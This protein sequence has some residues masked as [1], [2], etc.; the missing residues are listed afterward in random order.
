MKFTAIFKNSNGSPYLLN[1]KLTEI[2]LKKLREIRNELQTPNL[3]AKSVLQ[4]M[5]RNYVLSLEIEFGESEAEATGRFEEKATCVV[6]VDDSIIESCLVE[7]LK[8]ERGEKDSITSV[9][10]QEVISNKKPYLS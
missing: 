7:K 1:E 8:V 4:K 2:G 9:E 10:V 3:S 5:R 6:F